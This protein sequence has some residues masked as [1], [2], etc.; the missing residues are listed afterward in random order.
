MW[1]LSHTPEPTKDIHPLD[2]G[3]IDRDG[4]Y[5]PRWSEGEPLPDK[6]FGDEDTESDQV[7]DEVNQLD[8][9]DA[10]LY[11]ADTDTESLS[12]EEAWSDDSDSECG[13]DM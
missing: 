13:N 11:D 10:E 6:L 4:H 8:D 7:L 9:I 3:W 2:F 1:R 5:V 12:D